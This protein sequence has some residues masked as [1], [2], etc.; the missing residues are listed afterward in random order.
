MGIKKAV[1]IFPHGLDS[2]KK[3]WDLQLVGLTVIILTDLSGSPP[4]G[5][6]P[7]PIALLENS[8]L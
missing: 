8:G 1:R 5:V 7:P 3:P 6:K 4:V 2:I